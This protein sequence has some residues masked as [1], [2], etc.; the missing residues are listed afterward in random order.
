LGEI[1]FYWDKILVFAICLKQIL[2]GTKNWGALPPNVRL[3]YGSA[4]KA[5]VSRLDENIA[6][7]CIWLS[8]STS[9]DLQT[10][11]FSTKRKSHKKIYFGFVGHHCRDI[12]RSEDKRIFISNS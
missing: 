3:G 8:S 7:I 9:D 12:T 11:A 4:C 2:E 10:N 6:A 1:H 5:N